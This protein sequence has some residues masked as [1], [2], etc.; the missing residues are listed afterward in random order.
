MESA[1]NFQAVY[2]SKVENYAEKIVA[3]ASLNYIFWCQLY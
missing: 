2:L 1:K 3:N